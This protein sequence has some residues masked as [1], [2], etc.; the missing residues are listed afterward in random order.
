ML[1]VFENRLDAGKQL[2][3]RLSRLKGKKG[4]VVLAIPR[5]GVEV[6]YA[7]VL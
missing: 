5:G 4:V 7:V 1:M 2:A 6:G 3:A